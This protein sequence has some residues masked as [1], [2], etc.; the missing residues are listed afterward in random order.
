MANNSGIDKFGTQISSG[1]QLVSRW[2]SV[3]TH[4]APK[5]TTSLETSQLSANL[6]DATAHRQPKPR[7]KSRT[8][9]KSA[10]SNWENVSQQPHHEP[11]KKSPT[12]LQSRW[13]TNQPSDQSKG[14]SVQAMDSKQHIE[15]PG[16]PHPPHRRRRSSN[17]R[18]GAT[19]NK[20]QE[21]EQA[22]PLA[23]RLAP[24]ST[25]N[26]AKATRHTHHTKAPQARFDPTKS[27]P[28][29]P[30]K[31]LTSLAAW[32]DIIGSRGSWA[33]AEEDYIPTA[34]SWR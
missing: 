31:D 29:A 15:R 9:S 1:D 25:G 24:R 11:E 23:S 21:P 19:N 13:A 16:N 33:D 28:D 12:K 5:K 26:S 6:S 2:A 34:K 22:N 17:N 7:S 20:S 14:A 8:H 18:K 30:Q 3:A 10:S 27:E 4:S 32:E